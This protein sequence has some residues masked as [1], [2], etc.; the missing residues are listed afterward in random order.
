MG[1]RGV[2][3]SP[4]ELGRARV[5]SWIE[6]KAL[7]SAAPLIHEVHGAR[8]QAAIGAMEGTI[9]ELG[10]G[11]GPNF[12]YYRPGVKVIAIEPNPNWHDALRARAA[13][14]GIDLEIRTL[15]GE[16]IDLDDEAADGVVGTLVLCGVDDPAAVVAEVRRILKPGGTYFFLEHVAAEPGSRMRRVQDLALRPHRW[17]A[18]GCEP[19]RDTT[20]VIEAGGFSRLDHDTVDPGRATAYIRPHLIGVAVK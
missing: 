12:R 18:N 13:E 20:A 10:P 19:N 1:T 14:T 11:S 16:Q 2:R 9:V 5:R 4:E 7:D 17:V 15:R 6:R 3:T 8:K